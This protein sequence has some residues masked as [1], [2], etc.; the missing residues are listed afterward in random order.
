M[1]QVRTICTLKAPR[2]RGGSQDRGAAWK[3][4]LVKV[5]TGVAAC[6]TKRS[7]GK[8]SKEWWMVFTSRDQFDRF[9]LEDPMRFTD[10]LQFAHLRTQFDHVFGL[11]I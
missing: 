6:S 3:V 11:P 8:S 9:C 10:P 2:A 1:H 7:T 5:H 4:K